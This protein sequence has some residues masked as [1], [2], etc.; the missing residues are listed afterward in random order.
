MQYKYFMLS[1]CLFSCLHL[2]R[3]SDFWFCRVFGG[4]RGVMVI[5]VGNEHGETSSNP[6]RD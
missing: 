5:V 2:D 1:R 3:I 6:G 4:A